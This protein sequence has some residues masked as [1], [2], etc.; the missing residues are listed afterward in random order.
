M[1]RNKRIDAHVRIGPLPVPLV[2]HSDFSGFKSS[3]LKEAWQ[4]IGPSVSMNIDKAPIWEVIAAAYLEGLMHGV[5]AMTTVVD[6]SG[7]TIRLEPEPITQI[8]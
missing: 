1:S 2:P 3:D 8:D 5:G 7:A 6:D 4:L